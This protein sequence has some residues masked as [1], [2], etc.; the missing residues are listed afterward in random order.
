MVTATVLL[1]IAPLEVP[2][3]IARKPWIWDTDSIT[4]G[5]ICS[6]MGLPHFPALTLFLKLFAFMLLPPWVC[7]ET[8]H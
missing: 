8:L 2:N 3:L 7:G 5:G 1:N 6:G 4:K